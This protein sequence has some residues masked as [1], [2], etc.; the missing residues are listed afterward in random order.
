MRDLRY[1]FR[2]LWKDR[3][4]AAMAVLSLAVGIGANTAIF[5]LVNGVLLRPLDFPDPERLVSIKLSSPQFAGGRNLPINVA[6]L[7]AWRK[8]TQF[9]ESIGAY[10][11]ATMSLTGD[12]HPELVGAAVVSA[13]LF[14]VLGVSPQLGRTFVDEEDLAGQDHVVLIADS[15]WRRRFGADPTIVGRKLNL[16]GSSYTVVGVL[17]AGFA[18]PKEP[19]DLGHRMTAEMEIFRPIGYRPD[20]LVFEVG[21]LNY[22]AIARLKPGVPGPRALADLA[23]VESAM[24]RE[25]HAKVSLIPEIGS[26]Q[27]SMTG[28]V[29]QSLLVLMAAVGSVLLVLC[30]NLA[31][32]S[33]SRAAGRN[34]DAAIRTA[35]GATRGDLARQSLAETAIL[36]ILGGAF[37]ILLASAGL[38]GLIAAAPVDLPRLSEVT[39]DVWVLGFAVALS[40]ATGLLFG[41][42][43]AVRSAAA[44]SVF[45][46]LRAGGANTAGRG[47]LRLRNL[48]VSLEVG[49]CAALLVTAGLFLASFVR[50]TTIPKGFDIERVLAVDVL[51]PYAKYSKDEDTTRFFSR[52][53]DQAKALPGVEAASISSY[54][55][56][57]GESWVDILRVENDSRPEAQLPSANLRFISPGYFRTLR[58]PLRKGRDFETT[59]QN[60]KVAVISES[61]AR[62]LWPG[63]DPIGRKLMDIG[64][65]HEVVGVVGDARSTSLDQSPVD[66][67]YIPLWQ[68]PQN[69]SSVL[70]RTAMDS[71]GI[72][73]AL[74]AAVWAVD[75]D[76][77]VPLEHTLTQI[78]SESVARRRFQMTLVV[79]FAA[80]A[81]VLAAL[82]TYGVVS[83]TVTR[84]RPEIGIRM[85]LGAGRGSVLGLIL[86]QGM[87]PVFAGLAGGAIAALWIGQYVSSL[88]FEVSPHDPTA[89]AISA[90]VLAVVS[91][92]ACWIPAQRAT[93]VNPIEAL[94]VE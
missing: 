65:P 30:V 35:L 46:T 85:A 37:G 66:M 91:A 73:S 13:N 6:Q 87:T 14:H 48:L 9:F 89:F 74:R 68:R 69:S 31:N 3:G 38:K 16:R 51:L 10:R 18:F 71:A 25:I 20:D 21:D 17:P 59:D 36:S 22:A 1:A 23:S 93:R 15:L 76:V 75:K 45:D 19:Q 50:L 8:R 63:Q 81:L 58:I 42:L 7:A 82:G 27:Q 2:T 24:E 64:K 39:L 53:L 90:T 11:N 77:P 52:L 32:L 12:G 44:V 4:F 94:R 55:P 49:L 34:R 67:L 80:A 62:K 83:Y 92:A 40:L 60:R 61:L 78:M 5:S 56:L 84:R 28:D 47:G 57:R 33:L 70:V 54:L 41:T 88:L 72:A 26:L 86:R 43:P 79:L 29:R